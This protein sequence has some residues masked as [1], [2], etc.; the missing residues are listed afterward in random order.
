[1]VKEQKRIKEK[2]KPKPTVPQVSPNLYPENP[3]EEAK[4]KLEKTKE[5]LEKGGRAAQIR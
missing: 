4:K 1:V 3:K 5:K 2:T